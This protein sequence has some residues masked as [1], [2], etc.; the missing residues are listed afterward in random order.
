MMPSP[1]GSASNWRTGG[2][3]QISN[4]R[5]RAKAARQLFQFERARAGQGD[6]LAEHF[7][8][9]HESGIFDAAGARRHA[10]GPHRGPEAKA[11][12]SRAKCQ[13]REAGVAM[14]HDGDGERGRDPAVPGAQG[15]R[16]QPNQVAM[17]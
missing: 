12:A 5:K 17:A 7:V 13:R 6:P 15:E 16:P 2:G 9:H 1:P 8:H 11:A 4:R 14:E 3:F 10:G